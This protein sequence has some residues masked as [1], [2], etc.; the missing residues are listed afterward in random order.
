MNMSRFVFSSFYVLATL[1]SVHCFASGNQFE[2]LGDQAYLRQ[3]FDSAINYYQDAIRAENTN[4]LY[5]YKLGNAHY[6][7]HHIGEAVLAYERCLERS[8]SFDAA[9]SNITHIQRNIQGG[10]QYQPI[11]FIQL[12]Q[13]LVAPSLS[14]FYAILAL[15]VVATPLLILSYG[16]YKRTKIVWLRPQ[17]IIICLA[18]GAVLVIASIFSAIKNKPSQIAVVMRPDAIFQESVSGAEKT[19]SANLP[20]GLVVKVLKKNRESMQIQLP[21][22]QSGKISVSDVAV[23]E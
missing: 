20:E 19:L 6:R 14:N 3:K 8:P 23:I 11:A 7:M 12:L 9:A 4:A 10:K 17:A 18:V 16:K 1:I 13:A 15:L 22:G 21:N 5:W 2:K